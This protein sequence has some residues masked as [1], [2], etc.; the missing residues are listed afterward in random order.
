MFHDAHRPLAGRP[1]SYAFG[2]SLLAL[3]AAIALGST[4]SSVTAQEAPRESIQGNASPHPMAHAHAQPPAGFD[5]LSASDSKL[6]QFG[7]PPRP[8]AATAPDRYAVWKKLVTAP[9][10]R[11]APTLEHTTIH[12]GRARIR[13]AQR[14][15]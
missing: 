4:S 12:N 1:V 9:Q 7:F 13:R 15:Q 2:L 8:D 5:P 3:T 10:K 14:S 6:A 11:L